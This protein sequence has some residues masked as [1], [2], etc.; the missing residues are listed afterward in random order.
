MG[1]QVG[2]RV[3][4]VLQTGELFGGKA[5]ENAVTVVEPR[6]DKDMDEGSGGGEGERWTE[7][8]DVFPVEEGSFSELVDGSQK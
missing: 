2:G 1:Q 7:T 6:N 8:G 5:V 4:D 3:L